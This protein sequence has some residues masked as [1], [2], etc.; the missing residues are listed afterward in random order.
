MVSTSFDPA[1]HQ[2]VAGSGP[3]HTKRVASQMAKVFRSLSME[4][5]FSQAEGAA[6]DELSVGIEYVRALGDNNGELTPGM[7][8]LLFN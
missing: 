3:A 6:G 5:Q 8:L 2:P 1:Q 7:S 4:K